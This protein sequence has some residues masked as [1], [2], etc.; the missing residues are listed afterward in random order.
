MAFMLAFA[1][2]S[3]AQTNEKCAIAASLFV[4]P[5]KAKNYENALPHYQKV[6]AECPKFSLSIYQYAERMFK[7]FIE[8]GDTSKA[9]G[10]I[11]S[12]KLR[13]LNFPADTKEGDVLADIAQV[14]YDNNMGTKQEQFDAF[15][16]VFKKYPEDFTSPKSLYTYFSLGKD[17]FE[18]GDKEL[19]EIFD[20]YDSVTQQLDTQ[21]I[22]LA[23][24]LTMY[25]EKQDAGEELSAKDAS[26][27]SAYET[28]LGI[29]G[30]VKGSV[31]SK[32][33]QLADCENLVPLYNKDFEEKKSDIDWI[34]RAAGRLDAKD[35]S[36]DPL[37]FKLV[38]QMDKLEPSAETA[39]YL[40]VLADK[41]GKSKTALDYYNKAAELQT[42]KSKKAR[43]YYNIAENF[44]KSGSYGTARSY[45]NKMVDAKPNSGIAYLRIAQMYAASANSCGS[46]PFEKRAIYWKAA[47]M[48]DRA[49]RVDGAIASNANQA[50]S[51][52]RQ[53]APGKSDIFGQNMA[54]KTVTF[55]CWVGGSVRVPNL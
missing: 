41:D 10:L 6:V 55:N 24:S 50:A 52:Y 13:L 33:G 40:G 2:K 44:R 22:K 25:M 7:Y 18:S 17:L 3:F 23:E 20:L 37:F 21:E 47:E 28:N 35:C 31:D 42:D 36:E 49:A 29:F 32:L 54:G 46:T 34:K 11:E 16:E 53:S 9:E 39:Y 1:G 8:Q 19:Q 4:E 43:I 5:A 15:D 48:A 12:Y 38:Q 14:R 27:M 45:Y 51:S 26:R 30:K